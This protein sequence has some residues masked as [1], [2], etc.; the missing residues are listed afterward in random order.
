MS[1]T[2]CA[3]ICLLFD[4]YKETACNSE[5]LQYC[6]VKGA[7]VYRI[8]VLFLKDVVRVVIQLPLSLLIGICGEVM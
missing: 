3:D 6:Q 1:D 7:T 2:Q 4:Y 5:L 8:L